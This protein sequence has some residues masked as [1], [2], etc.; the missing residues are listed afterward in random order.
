[1]EIEEILNNEIIGIFI[2]FLLSII[3]LFFI[4]FI[5][6]RISYLWNI[7]QKQ[8][9][10]DLISAREFYDLYGKFFSLWKLWNSSFTDPWCSAPYMSLD[11]LPEKFRWYSFEE[12]CKIESRMEAIFVQV[13]GSKALK[14]RD[15]EVLGKFRQGFQQI[16]E[17]IRSNDRLAWDSATH[18]EYLAFKHL[19]TEVGEILSKR[20]NTKFKNERCNV[21][22]QECITCNIWETIW[23]EPANGE[24]NACKQCDCNNYKELL[25]C[26][27]NKRNRN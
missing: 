26:S 12:A 6:Q 20:R 1:M 3:S 27:N 15:V 9:E 25:N 21:L 23:P 19:G 13:S 10:L 24:L 14:I 17:T 22:F 2:K 8:K 18:P 7:R 5:G 4:W 16:R 11:E